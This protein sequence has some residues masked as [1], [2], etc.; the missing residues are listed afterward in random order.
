VCDSGPRVTGVNPLITTPCDGLEFGI[1]VGTNNNFPDSKDRERRTL[2]YFLSVAAIAL[3]LALAGAWSVPTDT[4][5][6]HAATHGSTVD[7]STVDRQS[8]KGV[9][10]EMA[11]A[12]R[13]G[14][15]SPEC[16]CVDYGA[17]R[18]PA[19]VAMK[20]VTAVAGPGS[21]AGQ[22]VV[23]RQV[24]GDSPEARVKAREKAASE[25]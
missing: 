13:T 17:L 24:R 3:C 19:R 16:W 6:R 18:V 12:P 25:V 15:V 11:A 20:Q 9:D 22:S 5:V 8:V 2:K 14:A 1:V 10:I 7:Q 4:A 23:L 21:A